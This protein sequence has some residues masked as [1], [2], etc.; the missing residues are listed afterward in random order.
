MNL[1]AG[2]IGKISV[3]LDGQ[4]NSFMNSPV[5]RNRNLS[6]I[7]LRIKHLA[8]YG[9]RFQHSGVFCITN[10]ISF[11]IISLSSSD[12][13]HLVLVQKGSPE[14]V[15]PRV[16]NFSIL[17]LSLSWT[18]PMVLEFF[19]FFIF[20]FILLIIQVFFHGLFFFLLEVLLFGF[21]FLFHF[22]KALGIEEIRTLRNQTRIY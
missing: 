18:Y 9:L 12:K 21:H 19:I 7:T 20:I 6:G 17:I 3:P 2:N 13:F 4:H 15:Y 16:N 5:Q 11:T 8:A 22:I 14:V 1:R 10:E